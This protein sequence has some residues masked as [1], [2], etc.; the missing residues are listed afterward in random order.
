MALGD[1][2]R[3]VGC[4]EVVRPIVLIRYDVDSELGEGAGG[5][6]QSKRERRGAVGNVHGVTSE[7]ECF[8]GRT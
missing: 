3:G 6:E 7:G 1:P 8:R 2:A 4:L 5:E